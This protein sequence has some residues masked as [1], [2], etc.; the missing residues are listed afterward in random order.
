MRCT[1]NDANNSLP[2]CSA[3][4]HRRSTI[5]HSH[6]VRCTQSVTF[7]QDLECYVGTIR[8]LRHGF[9]SQV[10]HVTSS[11]QYQQIHEE[12]RIVSA[13][14]TSLPLAAWLLCSQVVRGASG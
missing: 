10:A 1:G 2:A 13:I 14:L 12:N 4:W 9:A 6:P 5:S 7:A 11:L 8:H 3:C